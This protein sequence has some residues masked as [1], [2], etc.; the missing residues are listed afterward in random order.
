MPAGARPAALVAAFIVFLAFAMPAAA[1][2]RPPTLVAQLAQAAPQPTPG[3]EPPL[4]DEPPTQ[5]GGGDEDDGG[6]DG[7]Q[8]G[9]TGG[10]KAPSATAK[11]LAETGS[12][13]GMLALAGFALLGWGLALRLRLRD[14]A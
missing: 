5:L 3:E 11:P 1:A 9:K 14:A 8:A 10:R 2:E 13:A 12:Q 4:S 6:D 7:S